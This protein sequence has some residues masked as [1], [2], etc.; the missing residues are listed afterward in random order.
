MPLFQLKI[1]VIMTH[2]FWYITFYFYYISAIFKN[3]IEITMQL[4][5]Q[6]LMGS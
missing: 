2:L 3:D 1:L 6:K 5:I 4:Y